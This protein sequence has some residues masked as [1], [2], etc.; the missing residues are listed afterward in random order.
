M[1]AQHPLA[2]NYQARYRAESDRPAP[3][4]RRKK[5]ACGATVT[6]KQLQQFGCCVKC[7][8]AA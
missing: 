4:L 3:V 7:A 5:C 8:R 6:A 1:N 2:A